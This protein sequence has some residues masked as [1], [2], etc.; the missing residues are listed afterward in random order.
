MK[1]VKMLT[2]ELQGAYKEYM[3]VVMFLRGLGYNEEEIGFLFSTMNAKPTNTDLEKRFDELLEIVG[4]LNDKVEL[5]LEAEN[6]Q[7]GCEE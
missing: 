6:K 7:S 2:K 1:G 4:K 5:K 3:E